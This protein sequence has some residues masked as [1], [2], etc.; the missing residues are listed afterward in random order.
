VQGVQVDLAPQTCREPVNGADRVIAAAVEAP[1]D[2]LLD[3]AA[4]RLEQRRRGQGG[5]GHD[6]AG[7]LGQQPPEP[8][9]RPGVAKAEQ[10]RQ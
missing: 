8:E 10:D 5:G 4:Q 3:P 7:A 1:V 9:H 2:Q 6:Q